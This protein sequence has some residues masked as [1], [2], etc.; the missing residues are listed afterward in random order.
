[1]HPLQIDPHNRHRVEIG[2]GDTFGAWTIVRETLKRGY[3][4]HF[5]CQCS[6]GTQKD[7]SLGSL[8]SGSSRSCGCKNRGYHLRGRSTRGAGAPRFANLLDRH[9]I[10]RGY[11]AS[12]GMAR[13]IG[14][15]SSLIGDLRNNAGHSCPGPVLI[16]RIADALDISAAERAA[17]HMAAARDRGY[18]LE[19]FVYRP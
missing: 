19:G 4:R 6:C 2:P 7:L 12:S 3:V 1:M 5:L 15:R 14:A 11:G 10:N 16:D 9:L 18:R 8:R 13:K 17:L